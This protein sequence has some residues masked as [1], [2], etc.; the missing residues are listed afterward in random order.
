MKNSYDNNCDNNDNN[1]T[2]RSLSVEDGRIGM[3]TNAGRYAGRHAERPAA[4]EE[5]EPQIA[6]MSGEKPIRGGSSRTAKQGAAHTV[7]R[8]DCMFN[9]VDTQT[10]RRD[11]PTERR[12]VHAR[13]G[14]ARDGL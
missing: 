5:H 1:N 4:E 11:H 14:H 7:A 6:G 12:C 13:L 9:T 8:N 10:P 3:L 2:R